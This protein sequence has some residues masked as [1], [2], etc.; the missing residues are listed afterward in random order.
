VRPLGKYL[1]LEIPGWLGASLVLYFAHR[2][3]GLSSG[4]AWVLL[5]VWIGKDFALYPA[6]RGALADDGNVMPSDLLIGAAGVV[7]RSLDR[8]GYV[9]V[10]AELWRARLEGG[11]AAAEIRQGT[12]VRV[13]ALQDL[14]LSVEAVSDKSPER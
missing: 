4:L 11:A 6:L 12:R 2:S 10:G 14:T 7:T 8:E 3:W 9:R 5:A 1:L 13:T